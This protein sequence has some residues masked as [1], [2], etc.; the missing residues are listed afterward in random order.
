[1]EATVDWYLENENWL[2]NVTSGDYQSYYD[3]HYLQ[4]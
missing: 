2:K 4:K 3:K 1:M